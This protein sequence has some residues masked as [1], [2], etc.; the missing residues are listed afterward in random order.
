MEN[1]RTAHI[2]LSIDS[3]NYLLQLPIDDKMISFFSKEYHK[4]KNIRKV[5]SEESVSG[6]TY[7]GELFGLAFILDDNEDALKQLTK[8]ADLIVSLLETYG[9]TPTRLTNLPVS[10]RLALLSGMSDDDK[11]MINGFNLI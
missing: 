4:A 2:A 9:L 3:D 7:N 5:T 11:D 8:E 10:D 1:K 6:D